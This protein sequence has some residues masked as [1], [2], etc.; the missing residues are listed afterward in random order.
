MRYKDTKKTG[1]Q[2]PELLTDP[3]PGIKLKNMPGLA[4]KIVRKP[5]KG[6]RHTHFG[7]TLPVWEPEKQGAGATT[8][9]FVLQGR[10]VS[11]KNNQMAVVYKKVARQW[12]SKQQKTGRKPTW[13]DVD[14]ILGI[15][16]A[17]FIGNV[18][19]SACKK[20]F[21]PILEE[22]KRIWNERLAAKGLQFPLNK[23]SMSIRFYFKD[24]Y[25]T[26]TINKQQTVQDL[27]IEA[28]II[29]NDDYKTINPISAVSKG[30]YG[31]LVDNIAVVRLSFKLG[32][33]IKITDVLK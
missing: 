14:T 19:Y 31:K 27:L 6:K 9:T 32:K 29:S 28:G 24:R 23:A 8:I 1:A 13:D 11:K 3:S 10:V 22:Q 30:F 18:L 5:Q 16:S 17:K 15:A 26:D 33:T 20:K 21:V 7:V 12:I 25:I 2:T 4:K